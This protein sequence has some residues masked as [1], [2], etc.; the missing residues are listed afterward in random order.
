MNRRRGALLSAGQDSL[1]QARRRLDEQPCK[2]IRAARRDAVLAGTDEYAR[3]SVIGGNCSGRRFGAECRVVAIG[4]D[5]LPVAV[6]VT[7]RSGTDLLQR[8]E[9]VLGD[10]GVDAVGA[11]DVA[12]LN[13]RGPTQPVGRQDADHAVTA[14]AEERANGEAEMDRGAGRPGCIDEQGVEDRAPRMSA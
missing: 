5:A 10:D 4:V 2:G 3:E 14:V 12:G 8:G 13:C 6:L 7:A 9:H 1:G 11:H